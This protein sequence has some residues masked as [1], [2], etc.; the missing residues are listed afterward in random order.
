MEKKK[1]SLKEIG[2][3]RLI[4]LLMA[5]ILIILLSVPGIFGSKT[6]KQGNTSTKS[7][8]TQKVT[9]TTSHDSNT[10][11]T[12]MEDKLKKVLRK[13][14]GIGNVDVMITLKA[15]EE[16]VPLKDNPYTQEGVNEN[17]GEGGSRADNSVKRDENTVL[18]T[19][20]DGKSMPY[21]IQELEPKVEGVVVIAEGGDNSEVASNIV[22]AA[23][24]LFN[25]PAYKIKVMKM[26]DGIK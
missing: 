14:S 6:T 20:E 8:I 21:I 2:L 5:G 3:P 9:N 26:S 12:E 15:S 25:L 16:Q 7:N 10:Y 1:I 24:V 23:Q 4:M 19:T 13:V 18:V 22:Q 17:D 11:I